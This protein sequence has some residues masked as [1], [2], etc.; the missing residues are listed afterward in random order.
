MSRFELNA[1]PAKTRQP[2]NHALESAMTTSRAMKL[3]FC[4]V[5]SAIPT[6]TVADDE[7][8]VSVTRVSYSWFRA[9]GDSLLL[10]TYPCLRLARMDS[11]LLSKQR[12]RFADDD[13]AC[14]VLEIY[15]ATDT[16]TRGTFPAMNLA[17]NFYSVGA[18]AAVRLANCME[19]G[20]QLSGKLKW[21][22]TSGVVEFSDLVAKK[23]TTCHVEAIYQLATTF[24]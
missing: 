15:R 22:G 18:N 20:I 10:H 11:A 17:N 23:P 9:N 7:V 21:N 24:P 2:P 13:T 19:A 12:L 3:V 6:P 1:P 8:R 5:A 4:F 16:F 14:T